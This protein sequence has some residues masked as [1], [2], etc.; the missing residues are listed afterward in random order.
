M[1]FCAHGSIPPLCALISCAIYISTIYVAKLALMACHL[2]DGGK[3]WLWQYQ[4]C[5]EEGKH[6]WSYIAEGFTEGEGMMVALW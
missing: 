5:W 4:G 3:L 6:G 2:E 1:C